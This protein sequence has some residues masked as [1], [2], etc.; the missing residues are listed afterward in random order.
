MSILWTYDFEAGVP[1]GTVMTTANSNFKNTV[2]A[3]WT[4]SNAHLLS[5][6]GGAL[7]GRV[8][9]AGGTVQANDNARPWASTMVI[10]YRLYVYVEQ[11]PS[12][13]TT[14][15]PL[16]AGPTPGP[17]TTASEFRITASGQAQ[18]RN[19]NSSQVAVSSTG[20]MGTG[21]YSRVEGKLDVVN[22][23]QQL[24]I[25][26]GSNING[27]VADYD[28]GLVTSAAGG[29]GITSFS[30]GLLNACTAALHIDN[31]AFS[32]SGWI[33]PVTVANLP[34]TANAGTNQT[35]VAPWSQVTLTGTDSDPDGSIASRVW[36][37]TGGTPVTYTVVSGNT[38][39]FTAPP[40]IK[41]DT[42]THQYTVTDDGGL[43]VSSTVQ[44]G[45]A[46]VTT[47][48]V[49]GGVEVP[50]RLMP[51]SSGP[52]ASAPSAPQNVKAT[53]SGTSAP[54]SAT[55][56]WAAPANN[57]GSPV[58][59]YN[60]TRVGNGTHTL[61]S[62]LT[63]TFGSLMVTPPYTFNVVAVNS[64][65]ASPAASVTVDV[66]T[67]PPPVINYRFPGDTLPLVTGKILLGCTEH[68]NDGMSIQNNFEWYAP[69]A[70]TGKK[71]SIIKTFYKGVSVENCFTPSTG[72]IAQD[73]KAQR[74]K[75]HIILANIAIQQSNSSHFSTW[76]AAG[77]S[78]DTVV[79]NTYFNFVKWCE[80]GADAP[81]VPVW[82]CM[83]HE[84]QQ[85]S[86]TSL[87][88]ADGMMP[89]DY[90]DMQV[91]FRKCMDDYAL[92]KTGGTDPTVYTWKRL[93]FGGIHTGE[94]FS[95]GKNNSQY[96]SK[97]I[98]NFYISYKTGNPIPDR[99]HD[100]VGADPY[101][102]NISGVMAD[103]RT[104]VPMWNAASKGMMDWCDL[105][106]RPCVWGEFGIHNTD[107]DAGPQLQAFWDEVT[108]G[109]HDIPAIIYFNSAP[110]VETGAVLGDAAGTG[111]FLFSNYKMNDP[112]RGG[113]G[114][115]Y[116]V[117]K[118][119]MA[120]PKVV[121]FWDIGYSKPPG[122]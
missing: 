116:N 24:K 84:A 30:L 1:S 73:M 68:D 80:E 48:A 32:N 93:A 96:A 18:I 44:V 15:L 67:Q 36:T 51:V 37:Q 42:G 72:G 78:A 13:S 29:V 102:G 111:R 75:G 54:Y 31:L 12:A 94:A 22:N 20:L 117:W 95:V 50:M 98:D 45:T 52:A 90:A 3:G 82:I 41:G 34:P 86:K 19:N 17:A 33:G 112:S 113:N 23:Q 100:F 88:P 118:T 63:D 60:V 46:P 83:P 43:S 6:G 11:A 106:T 65:G 55:I 81:D 59:G 7:A 89:G 38:V 27:S 92:S 103:G 9:A 77:N 40:T 70:E 2:Q 5:Q 79:Y 26:T 87:V 109:T 71:Y 14:V 39:T 120:D 61:G 21:T 49:S 91:A 105:H 76:R 74:A 47:R 25:F 85:T 4:F 58:T 122:V 35:N 16:W 101:Q 115:F 107:G 99:T 119:L 110:D 121:H 97:G 69:E 57:G 114:S 28:T 56:T 64:A 53:I 66:V 10:Y 104:G 108:N 62:V 8:S